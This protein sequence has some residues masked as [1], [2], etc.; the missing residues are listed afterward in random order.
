MFSRI[1]LSILALLLIASSTALYARIINVPD[2]FET[3]QAGIDDADDGDTVLVAPGEYE[4]NITT[5]GKGNITIGSLTLT[6]G[7]PDFIAETII[8]GGGNGQTVILSNM[9]RDARV[10]LQ[11]FTIRNGNHLYGAG[12]YASGAIYAE[13]IDLLVTGNQG[14][15]Y[16]GIA[17]MGIWDAHFRRVRIINNSAI[18]LNISATRSSLEDCDVSWNEEGGAIVGAGRISFQNV[19][20]LNNGG[21]GLNTSQ[22]VV[23]PFTLDHVT[24]AGTRM[25]NNQEG[26][27]LKLWTQSG[28]DLT[29]HLTNSIIYAN[30]GSAIVLREG[31][32]NSDA[33]LTVDFS[34]IEGGQDEIEIMEGGE[35]EIIWLD[36]N[37]DEDPLF[38]DLENGD[39]HLTIDSPCIDAGDPEAELD[40]D[41]TRADMGAFYFHQRDIDVDPYTL[42][43]VGVQIGDIDSL[44]AVVRNVGLTTL[45]LTSVGITSFDAP[46][47]VDELD[48]ALPIEPDSSHTIWVRFLPF[49]ENQYLAN[50][51]IESDDPDEATVEVLISASALSVGDDLQLPATFGISGVYPNPFNSVTT[52]SYSLPERAQVRLSLHDVSGR[53]VGMLVD[54]MESAG[55]YFIPWNATEFPSGVYFCRLSTNNKRRVTKL[56]LIR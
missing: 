33:Q 21:T 45:N 2:D 37:I 16:S 15:G 44:A 42:E 40:P 27:G 6:T 43:F 53:Q 14:N 28:S 1:T 11:G 39:Y 47:D 7:N 52:I 18:G 13:F 3:I 5:A 23:S 55:N 26:I 10:L 30:E 4:E 17:A 19:S 31:P 50:L 24:I 25:L 29:A 12:I 8:D 56:A 9:L 36:G 48:E 20:F 51:I 46:L 38:V 41:G 49:E 22:I 54:K 32:D 34:D 35:P